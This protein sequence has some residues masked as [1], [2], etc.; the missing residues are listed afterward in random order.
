MTAPKTTAHESIHA[1]VAAAMGDIRPLAKADRNKHDG[2]DFASIDGFLAMVRPICAHHGLFI[3]M[4][5]E[6]PVE[7]ARKGR[8]GET[9]YL[10][11]AYQIT[12]CH[13]SGQTLGPFTRRVE[14]LRNGPQAFGS[15][16]SYVLKQFLRG[17]LQIATGDQDDP[18]HEAKADGP[19]ARPEP[20][21]PPSETAIHT[22]K[23]CLASADSLDALREV[24][25]SLSKPVQ[26]H[27]D[28]LQA[29]DSRKAALEHGEN[30]AAAE[31]GQ[32]EIPY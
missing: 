32:D 24:W 25:G 12:V 11:M 27:P 17:L 28:V 31:I 20:P 14:V 5:E 30:T 7:F 18:D 4:D 23:E 26:A 3:L 9:P 13:A 19:I 21:A 29:K 2:Y 22:A 10:R 8:N 6:E 16:Q 15:G 1:A